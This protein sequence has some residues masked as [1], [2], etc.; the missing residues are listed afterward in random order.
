MK[1]CIT[2]YVHED[3]NLPK[4]GWIQSC[5]MCYTFTSRTI[6]YSQIEKRN[7]II[8][9][10]VYLCPSCKQVLTSKIRTIEHGKK[11][12]KFKKMYNV[13]VQNKV[14]DFKL[15]ELPKSQTPNNPDNNPNSNSQNKISYDTSTS[16]SGLTSSISLTSSARSTSSTSSLFSSHNSSTT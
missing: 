3:S 1:Y 4:K 6:F 2:Y 12:E 9:T 11:I 7:T 13:R 5:I 15:P 14:K 16:Y 8:E 10:Q